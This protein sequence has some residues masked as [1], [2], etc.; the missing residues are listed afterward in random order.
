M[1]KKNDSNS[2]L[3][4]NSTRLRFSVWVIIANYVI[5]IIG[6][7]IGTDLTAL[8]V[9][10]GLSN[11]PLYAYI[12]GRSFRGSSIPEQYY[13]QSHTGSGGITSIIEN[14]TSKK[15]QTFYENGSEPDNYNMPTDISEKNK[16]PE[17]P[18]T[19]NKNEEEIG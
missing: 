8:G 10:L 12:L 1:A 19:V 13:S 2:L 14:R 16:I 17:S 6:M 5:G 3:K 18:K 9:F 15:E 4:N 11:T 7:L